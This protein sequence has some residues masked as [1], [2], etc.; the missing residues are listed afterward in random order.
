VRAAGRRPAAAAAAPAT[1]ALR[2]SDLRVQDRPGFV[3]ELVAGHVATVLG[4]DGAHQVDLDRA[5]KD[6]GFDSLTGVE[7][8]NLLNAATGLRLPS[9]AVF[10]TPTPAALADHVLEQLAPADEAA[11][12][13]GLAE[14]ERL[15][16]GIAALPSDS[17]AY[18]EVVTRLVA[19]AR[20]AG[21][22]LDD[23]ASQDLTSVTDDEL[24][25]ALDDELGAV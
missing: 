8:R 15:E 11:G 14:L 10:D 3:R 19:L 5:F 21:E 13:P 12:P 17:E 2:L 25:A 7:L 1:V 24:F 23:D 6:M 22:R 9:T 18:R 16:A 4:Y 20:K